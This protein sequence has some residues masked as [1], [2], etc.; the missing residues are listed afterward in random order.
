MTPC[1]S[2]DQVPPFPLK[3]GEKNKSNPS[4]VKPTSKKTRKE[5]T[6]LL[7]ES[8]AE[9]GITPRRSHRFANKPQMKQI[10]V[11]KN[12]ANEEEDD[13]EKVESEKG[14]EEMEATEGSDSSNLGTNVPDSE[15]IKED[16]KNTSPHSNTSLPHTSSADEGG[17]TSADD[18]EKEEAVQ[19]SDCSAISKDLNGVKKKMEHPESYVNKIGKF[20]IKVM[21][22]SPSSLCF[23]HQDKA[24]LGGLESDTT[25]ELFQFL[26]DDWT[27]LMLSKHMGANN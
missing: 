2:S 11:R 3:I 12:Y 18:G 14:E 22:S 1:Q 8:D 16:I 10:V 23:L 26:G 21:D 7:V 27:R 15:T 9:D 5:P 19:C 6:I 4:T 24:D 20:A 17:K 13:Y 25:K